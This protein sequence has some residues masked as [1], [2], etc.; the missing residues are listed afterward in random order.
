MK[1]RTL[2]L[3]LALVLVIGCAIGGTVAW[4][5]DATDEVKN[6]FTTSDIGVEL[7]ESKNL[8]LKMI[9]GWEIKKDPKAW[10]TEGS[11]DAYLFVKVVES[12]N[13]A[14]FMTYEIAEGWTKLSNGVYYREV[15]DTQMGEANAF[16][17]LKDDKVTVRGEVT[18]EMM[19]AEGF[20]QP[21]LTFTAY[22]HQLYKNNTEK[23][24]AADAWKN[25]TT[26]VTPAE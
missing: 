26:P 14:D 7:E 12:E 9:P 4:L 22:A 19:T 23:F 2:A 13:F 11:E 6:V 10:I 16:Q 24:A 20:T 5:T 15:S 1:K 21:T 3:M 17:I 8:D 18:K 25:I